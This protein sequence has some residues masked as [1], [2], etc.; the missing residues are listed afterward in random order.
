MNIRHKLIL[1]VIL[2]IVP[3]L[4]AFPCP[5]GAA[6]SEASGL[7]ARQPRFEFLPVFEGQVVRHEF[8]LRNEGEAAVAIK[9]VK[10]D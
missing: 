8:V 5:A 6:D 3:W 4:Q 1:A 10:T 2:F 7:A 9:G